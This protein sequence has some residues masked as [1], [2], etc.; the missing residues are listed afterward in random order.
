LEDEESVKCCLDITLEGRN[1]RRRSS[2][3][4]MRGRVIGDGHGGCGRESHCGEER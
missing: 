1:E 3:H 4:G 2:R